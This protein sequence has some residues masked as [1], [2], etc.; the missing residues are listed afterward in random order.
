MV[1]NLG[2]NSLAVRRKIACLKML[3][4][5]YYKQKNL[6]NLAIPNHARCVDTKLKPIILLPLSQHNNQIFKQLLNIKCLV[7][8]SEKLKE[9]TN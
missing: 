5:I 8:F 1:Q 4:C 6:P 7:K 3:H 9:L 2:L